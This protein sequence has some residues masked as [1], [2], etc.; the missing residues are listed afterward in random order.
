MPELRAKL[1]ALR[2]EAAYQLARHRHDPNKTPILIPYEAR[3]R[4]IEV[5]ARLESR[6]ALEQVRLD[7]LQDTHGSAPELAARSGELRAERARLEARVSAEQRAMAKTRKIF[8]IR[9]GALKKA[10]IV[11]GGTMPGMH[12]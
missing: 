6:L 3:A 9:L 2:A 8:G 12:R 7:A 10:G 1:A 5:C 4:S 11:R